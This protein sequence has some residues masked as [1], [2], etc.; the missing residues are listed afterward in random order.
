MSTRRVLRAV[1]LYLVTAL[2]G[3]CLFAFAL[4]GLAPVVG[5]LAAT[6]VAVLVA[7]TVGI[8]SGR[9]WMP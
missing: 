8:V 4:C 7:W 3:G 6:L 5:D 2:I 1:A 9:L